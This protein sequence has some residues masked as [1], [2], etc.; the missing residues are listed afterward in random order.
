MPM[1]NS[2]I[3][4]FFFFYC[5]EFSH[6]KYNIYVSYAY[7]SNDNIKMFC[8]ILSMGSILFSCLCYWIYVWSEYP[9]F[10]KIMENIISLVVH[11]WG[12]CTMSITLHYKCAAH[13]KF[14]NLPSFF[15]CG[16]I[17][18][19][20]RGKLVV[21]FYSQVAFK[22]IERYNLKFPR[23]SR[24]CILITLFHIYLLNLISL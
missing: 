21:D 8:L 19:D 22:E 11:K 14:Y 20:N 7:S 18:R 23:K 4:P 3:Y 16:K 24:F 13:K 12:Y 9:L 10:A 2:L 6:L 5:S 17:F 15:I 1:S